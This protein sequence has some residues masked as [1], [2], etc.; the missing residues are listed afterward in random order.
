MKSSEIN[1]TEIGHILDYIILVVSGW[2]RFMGDRILRA[3]I[4]ILVIFKGSFEVN[5]FDRTLWICQ[6]S[7]RIL[8]RSVL[9]VHPDP[10]AHWQTPLKM[11]IE[12]FFMGWCTKHMSNVY[13]NVVFI[14]NNKKSVRFRKVI[15]I[16]S[17]GWD[18]WGR[19]SH[20]SGSVWP[21][22]SAARWKK[23]S[24]TVTIQ[25]FWVEHSFSN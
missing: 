13:Q 25:W 14:L 20:L 16:G 5:W 10:C 2:P 3:V 11:L 12:I 9:G 7:A 17:V 22:C 15:L 21:R 19:L 24:K 23:V 6:K 18:L 1:P 4:F 8:V